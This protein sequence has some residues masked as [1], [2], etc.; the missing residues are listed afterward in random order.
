MGRAILFR[1]SG[2]CARSGRVGC[3]SGSSGGSVRHMALIPPTHE[4]FCQSLQVLPHHKQVGI[5]AST[6]LRLLAISH[7]EA[8]AKKRVTAKLRDSRNLSSREVHSPKARVRRTVV[9][10]AVPPPRLQTRQRM[11]P[12]LCMSDCFQAIDTRSGI[13]SDSYGGRVQHRWPEVS[14]SRSHNV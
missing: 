8:K 2:R 3:S 9:K 12:R 14:G 13:Q 7:P 11:V 6:C 4:R 1:K 10:A 5:H